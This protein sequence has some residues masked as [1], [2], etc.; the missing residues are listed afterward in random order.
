MEDF[1]LNGGE[2]KGSNGLKQ[3]QSR[4]QEEEDGEGESVPENDRYFVEVI[5]LHEIVPDYLVESQA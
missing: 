3:T 4:C 5:I 2:L 1:I